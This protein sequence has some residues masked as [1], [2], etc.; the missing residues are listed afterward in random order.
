[1]L[2]ALAAQLQGPDLASSE[3][4]DMPSGCGSSPVTPA[5]DSRDKVQVDVAVH[6]LLLPWTLET[7]YLQNILAS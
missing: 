2:R 7:S 1:M 6:L 5:L 4:M 3:T